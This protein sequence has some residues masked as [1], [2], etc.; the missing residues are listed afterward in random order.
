MAKRK[1]EEILEDKELKKGDVTIIFLEDGV[2][3]TL[4]Y[5][6]ISTE[7][8]PYRLFKNLSNPNENEIALGKTQTFHLSPSSWA[9]TMAPKLKATR[10][11]IIRP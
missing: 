4:I 3:W 7:S 8:I 10:Y 6:G 11:Q 2:V 9:F 5:A 1:I